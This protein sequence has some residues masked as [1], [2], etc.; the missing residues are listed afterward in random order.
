MIFFLDYIKT[1]FKCWHSFNSGRRKL[2]L[3][4]IATGIL[5]LEETLKIVRGKSSVTNLLASN[6]FEYH[7]YSFLTMVYVSFDKKA[8]RSRRK[9][10]LRSAAP[11][12]RMW[13][14]IKNIHYTHTH[15]SD[16]VRNQGAGAFTIIW[17]SRRST[18]YWHRKSK[19]RDGGV[20][21]T[22]VP[23]HRWCKKR[24]NLFRKSHMS[25]VWFLCR[26]SSAP[27]MLRLPSLLKNNVTE[28]KANFS[29]L[30]SYYTYP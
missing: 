23:W 11:G 16:S 19:P 21:G 14:L 13:A 7:Y 27:N 3:Y 8:T 6:R 15:V 28:L 22:A 10:D 12:G 5:E 20:R 18:P 26:K 24:K 4:N 17:V 2:S 29:T 25:I 30:Y 1:V 9:L